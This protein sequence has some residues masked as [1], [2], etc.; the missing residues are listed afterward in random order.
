MPTHFA[1][2]L[3]RTIEEKKSCLVVGLDPLLERLPRDVLGAV[4]AGASGGPGATARAAAAFGLFCG[5][6][7]DSVKDVAVAVKPNSAFF[8]RYGAAGWECLRE[9]CRLA[10]KAGLIV[11]LDAKRGDIGHTAEAYADALMG[12][13]QDTPGPHVDAVTVNP[14]LGTDSVAPFLR[15]AREGGKGLFVLV[16]T[17]NASAGEL[18]DLDVGGAPL[19]LRVASLV[20]RWGA[21]LRGECGFSAVGAVVGATAPAEAKRIREALPGAMFLVPGYG[22]QGAEAAQLAACFLSGGR[23][24]IVN[25]SRSIIFA[26]EK[27]R[28]PWPDA[29]RAAAVEARDELNALRLGLS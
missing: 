12:G 13:L 3:A 29:I 6:V 11:I 26:Y 19:Y 28:E 18:Q 7:I 14:Y 20:E 21:D 25:A 5:K 10:S 22:A 2:R 9:V 27:R 17:S 23:G 16:R 15:L 4:G 8:E 1:D 24:A